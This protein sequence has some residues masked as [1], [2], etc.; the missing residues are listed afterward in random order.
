MEWLERFRKWYQDGL[1]NTDI[2]AINDLESYV[3]TGTWQYA[4]GHVRAEHRQILAESLPGAEWESIIFAE[5]PWV[6]DFAAWNFISV[7]KG[8]ENKVEA[9]KFLNWA[10]KRKT[11]LFL[12]LLIH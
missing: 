2:L 1:M 10:N 12:K 9:I 5:K 7:P 8:S 11:T 4:G 3:L 6:S